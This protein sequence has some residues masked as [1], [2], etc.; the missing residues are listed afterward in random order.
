MAPVLQ[1]LR[2]RFG[3]RFWQGFQWLALTTFTCTPGTGGAGHREGAQG[4]QSGGQSAMIKP[5]SWWPTE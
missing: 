5:K 2:T 4:A 1:C 3:V